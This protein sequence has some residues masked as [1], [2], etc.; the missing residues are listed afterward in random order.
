VQKLWLPVRLAVV[1]TCGDA[2]GWY[3]GDAGPT[4]PAPYPAF[5]VPTV[6][7]TGCGDVFHGAYASALARGLNLEERIRFSAAAAAIKATRRGAQAGIP[8]REETEAFLATRAS[9]SDS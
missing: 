5:A 9:G 4:A 3:R 7:T 1:V 6:D 2:G 8:T